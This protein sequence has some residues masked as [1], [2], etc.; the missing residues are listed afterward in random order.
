MIT[1]FNK[2]EFSLEM[3][4]N[5]PPMREIFQKNIPQFMDE[6]FVHALPSTISFEYLINECGISPEA[7]KKAQEEKQAFDLKFRK[8][9]EQEAS[10]YQVPFD[11]DDPKHQWSNHDVSIQEACVR[12]IEEIYAGRKHEIIFYGPSNIQMWYS[13]EQD[14][15]PY[16]AQNHGMGG[17]IDTEMMKYA[18]RMLYAFEP[19][20]VFFQTGSNDLANKIP[21]EEILENKK[22]MY[23]EFLANMPDTQLIVMSG[24]PLPGRMQFW[25][26][27]EKINALLKQMC[28]NTPRMQFM[29]ATD[30]FMKDSGDENFRAYNGKYFC[31]EYYRNDKIHLNKKGH[32]LWA[33]KMKE[34]LG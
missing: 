3:I 6:S 32:S 12:R 5:F 34:I 11:L 30:C 14:M 21:I 24:L 18:D 17:C 23:K 4:C 28:E 1:E 29:D 20:I 26:D 2:E 25:E 7:C 15:M 27:T 33:S 16:R 8:L 10:Q 13:L 22:K 31:P 19:K 9:M